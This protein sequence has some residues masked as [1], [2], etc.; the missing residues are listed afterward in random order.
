MSHRPLVGAG[1]QTTLAAAESMRDQ[2]LSALSEQIA[3]LA[4]AVQA[5]SVSAQ[6][7]SADFRAL[8]ERVNN[9][10][11]AV[12]RVTQRVEGFAGQM[13]ELRDHTEQFQHTATGDA[14]SFL[15]FQRNLTEMLNRYGISGPKANNCGRGPGQ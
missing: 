7:Q 1:P 6:Q 15:E 8:V 3:T 10:A 4:N 2:Q 11:A 13:G 12:Q 14:T 5:M 9:D